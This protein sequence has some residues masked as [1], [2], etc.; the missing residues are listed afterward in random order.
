MFEH[1]QAFRTDEPG[2]T[3]AQL[4]D[5][6]GH[7][8]TVHFLENYVVA[9]SNNFGYG[10]RTDRTPVSKNSLRRFRRRRAQ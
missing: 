1:L 4:N 5:P 2:H 8:C 7:V 9:V 6:D 3:C 10:L